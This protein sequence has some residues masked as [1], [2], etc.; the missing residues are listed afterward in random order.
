MAD[1]LFGWA[2]MAAA[3]LTLALLIGILLSLIAGAW[4]AIAKYGLGFLTSS[5]WDP[6][7]NEYGGLVMI[8]GTLMT[9]AIALLI[10]VPVSFGIALFLTELSPA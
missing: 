8:Y 10:A 5:T 1:R 2:A 4:P 7:Q 6:V 3:L 9:S